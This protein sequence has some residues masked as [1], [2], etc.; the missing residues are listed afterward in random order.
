ML[1]I[2]G[3]AV[4]WGGFDNSDQPIFTSVLYYPDLPV[5]QR[6]MIA[7]TSNIA[8]MYH[9]E[10]LL[11]EDGRV[12]ISGSTPNADANAVGVQ[13]PNEQRLEM[14][15]PPYL[16]GAQP[17]PVFSLF[18]ANCDYNTI[19]NIV[20]T[21]PSGIGQAVKVVLHT[22]GFVTH[23]THQGQR[24]V[25]LVINTITAQAGN[26]YVIN[27]IAPPRPEVVRNLKIYY[28]SC[29]QD[30]IC[31]LLLILE[32]LQLLLGFE[33]VVTQPVLKAG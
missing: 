11:L 20:S 25:E 29:L 23:S 6:F 33:L 28:F 30:G 1:I 32:Y 24:M 31:Y 26:Q 15:S 9:S 27:V 21:I 16:T 3:V 18:N 22:N 10:C 5:G 8:R 17:R 14:F 4:G 2:N 12:L 19:V 7:A 13:Y